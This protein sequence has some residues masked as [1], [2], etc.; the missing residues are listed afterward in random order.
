MESGDGDDNNEF[1]I[2]ETAQER[3]FSYVPRSYEISSS[4]RPSLNPEM[5]DVVVIDLDGLNDPARR[6]MIVNK[7]GNVCRDIGFFRVHF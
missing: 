7:I 1:P 3:A 6:P 2:G 5:A 4:N